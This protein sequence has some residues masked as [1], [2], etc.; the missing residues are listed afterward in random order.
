MHQ[1]I[2][3]FIQFPLL[4]W[5]LDHALC[6]YIFFISTFVGILPNVCVYNK[7]NIKF[8]YTF[9]INIFVIKKMSIE[10]Y[11]FHFKHNK[12]IDI[13]VIR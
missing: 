9:I 2:E 3:K 12:W 6:M 4:F 10:I 13:G 7:N 11:Q 5:V 1:I 8:E